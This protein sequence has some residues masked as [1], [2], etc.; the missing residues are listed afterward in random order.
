MFIRPCNRTGFFSDNT[1]E[2][3]ASVYYGHI[4]F[5]VFFLYF[6]LYFYKYPLSFQAKCFAPHNSEEKINL[7]LFQVV[8]FTNT[9]TKNNFRNDICHL[10]IIQNSW[11]RFIEIRTVF[12]CSNKKIGINWSLVYLYTLCIFSIHW[13]KT[14][15]S[16]KQTLWLRIMMSDVKLWPQKRL[17]NFLW[18]YA[19]DLVFTPADPYSTYPRNHKDEQFD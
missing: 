3:G 13:I 14:W 11:L 15:K 10:I 6:C 7:K 5:S 16:L 1:A 12:W 19:N 4:S 18:T 9:D 8:I 2:C 17:H